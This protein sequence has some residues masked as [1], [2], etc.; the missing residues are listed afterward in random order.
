MIEPVPPPP[1][2]HVV[3][4]PT[5][6]D[7]GA[8]YA[9]F[10]SY[11]TALL[12]FA[13]V[14]VDDIVDNLAEPGFDPAT[15]AWLAHGA[16]G[17]PS[18]YGCVFGGTGPAEHHVEVAAADPELE[19]WLFDRVLARSAEVASERGQ[20]EVA[21]D[22]GIYRNDERLRALAAEAGFAP[23]TTFQRLRID[24]PGAV[25]A[26]TLPDGVVVRTG[27]EGDDVRR[28]AHAVIDAAFAGQFGIVPQ[29]YDEWHDALDARTSFTWPQLVVLEL[30]G[31]AVAARIDNDQFV[32]DEDCGYVARLAVA[33]DVRGRGLAKVLLRD[34][35]ATHAAAG[36]TGTIL[37]V[38]TNNPT[39]ALDLYRSVGMD[40]VL[41]IDVWRAT[42]PT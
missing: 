15:D 6:A 9:V 22:L 37:H 29:T 11:N 1:A 28:A 3:R 20:D 2:G 41:V 13:D 25:A 4:R 8:I 30:D 24:H 42:R 17:R 18:G 16:D 19:R 40:L 7:I 21:V 5:E 36:R 10:A 33:E 14:T 34:A 26:P 38:D 31:R 27:D 23:G 35:F 39:P 32:G 12:G